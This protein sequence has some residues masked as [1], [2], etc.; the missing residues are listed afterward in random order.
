[1]LSALIKCLLIGLLLATASS[2]Q[3]PTIDSND[4]S[5]P[6]PDRVCLS[7]ILIRA[8]EANAPAQITDARNKAE[9]IRDA[10]RLGGQF[11]DL[12]LANSQGPSAKVGGAI[13]CFKRGALA[14]P[15]EEQVFPMKIGEFSDVLGTKQGFVI[16][17]VTGR[18]PAPS[19]KSVQQ[20]IQHATGVQGTVVDKVEHAPIGDAYVFA[21]RIRG[22]DIHVRTD[23]SG[24][25]AMPLPEGIYDVLVSAEGFSPTSRKI[26]V[27]PDG[28]MIFNAILE[29]NTLGMQID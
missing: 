16:L 1:M 3:N 21:H 9:Q 29:G 15:V 22:T 27:T 6:T 24:K 25:F 26:E 11:A 2:A 12:A 18:E 8:Q 13:G 4:A 28:M 5:I 23:S 10:L 19:L 17:Q 7:E 14:K 20:V